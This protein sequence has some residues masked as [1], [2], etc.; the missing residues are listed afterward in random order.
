MF[1]KLKQFVHRLIPQSFINFFY[2]FPQAFFWTLFYRY[3][4]K[5][6]TVIGVTGTD[7]KTTTSTLIWHI[8]NQAGEKCGLISSVS[9]KIGNQTVDTG[10]HVTTPNPKNLQKFLRKMKN[11]GIK[12]V[13]LESTS[14]GLDQY[15]LWGSNFQVGVI[16]NVTH[17]HLD[18]HKTLANYLKAKR[19]LFKKVKIAILNR[20]DI[21]Y[22]VIKSYINPKTKTL[23]YA[24][25]NKADFTLKNFKFTAPLRGKYNQYNCLAAI[26]TA[27]ALKIK[28]TVTLKAL[29]NFKGVR[30]R[31]EEVNLGQ[32]FKVFIDFAHTPNALNCVL[33]TLQ[34]K[35]RK[36]GKL[37]VV[38]GAAGLRD[39][40]KRFK[41]GEIVGKY[42]DAIILTAEDPRTE[43]VNDIINQIA[44][45]C[46]KTKAKEIKYHPNKFIWRSPYKFVPKHH[47]FLRVPDR[48][49]AINLAIQK[50]AR[51]GD[52]IVICG[53]GPEK[54]MCFGNKEYPWSDRKE[55][56]KAIKQRSKLKNREIYTS[57]A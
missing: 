52:I 20:D 40:T 22:Q 42:A 47:Y 37:I 3:P 34:K 43:N 18:Y 21:S 32:N 36:R 13:V 57:K 54:S 53:K 46:L 4:T 44:Q 11:A 26:A 24:I 14:H 25:K 15:R 7:G 6:L 39:K 8:L 2:H 49:K 29:A 10:L 48:E 12:F 27:N 31:M 41:M 5:N 51:K 23:T 30:G 45:G 9:A 1:D 56:E 19:R 38:F 17:E 16:T 35:L 28:K 55:T 33:P 50:I